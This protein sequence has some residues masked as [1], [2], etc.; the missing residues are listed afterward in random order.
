KMSAATPRK[1]SLKRKLLHEDSHEICGY[2]VFVGPIKNRNNGNKSPYF[3]MYISCEFHEVRIVSFVIDDQPT[4]SINVNKGYSFLDLEKENDGAYKYHCWSTFFQKTPQF[5]L[6]RFTQ[7][8]LSINEALQLALYSR[9]CLNVQVKKLCKQG[10]SLEG[11][12]F[13]VVDIV[14]NSIEVGREL[15]VYGDLTRQLE[16]GRNYQINYIT[17]TRYSG[18][19]VF[20]TSERSEIVQISQDVIVLRPNQTDSISGIVNGVSMSS[21]DP[22]YQCSH[23]NDGVIVDGSVAMCNKCDKMQSVTS[24]IKN[25]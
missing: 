2:V 12:N 24:L 17:L 16:V 11:L 20:K 23:C 25:T 10:T 4:L 9:V 13:K 15:T 18:I 1:K 5:D 22:R 14:D 3:E 8:P 19:K 21:L 6:T 7:E